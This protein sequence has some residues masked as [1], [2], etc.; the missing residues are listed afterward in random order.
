MHALAE[1]TRAGGAA[2]YLDFPLGVNRDGYDVWRERS[3][4]WAGRER[5]RTAGQIFL[6]KVR[7][8]ASRLCAPKDF[9]SKV[10]AITS[11]VCATIYSHAGMLRIDHVMGLAPFILDP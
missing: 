7:T 9:D 1:K 8:G 5:R 4:F 11:S 6:L 10:I 2:L 3:V